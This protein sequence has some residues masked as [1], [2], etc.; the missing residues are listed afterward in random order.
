MLPLGRF[1]ENDMRLVVDSKDIL[2][3]ASSLN[4]TLFGSGMIVL[5]SCALRFGFILRRGLEY[6][7]RDCG[8][9]WAAIGL[10]RIFI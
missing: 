2:V 3:I 10:N 1:C 5:Q 8:T 7:V 9:I 6:M 4:A